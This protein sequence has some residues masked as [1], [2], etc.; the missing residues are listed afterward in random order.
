MEASNSPLEQSAC[1][2]SFQ[3]ELIS[4]GGSSQ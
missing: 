4:S 3:R 2:F 1:F